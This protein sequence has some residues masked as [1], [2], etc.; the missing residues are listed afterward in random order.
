M[1]WKIFW[2]SLVLLHYF[3]RDK[4]FRFHTSH[5]WENSSWC[6]T[7][8]MPTLNLST[9]ICQKMGFHWQ[10]FGLPELIWFWIWFSWTKAKF[11]NCVYMSVW[12]IIESSSKEGGVENKLGNSLEPWQI[13]FLYLRKRQF[14]CFQ[15]LIL[16]LDHGALN[17]IC[18][19][20]V[21]K[22]SKT[23]KSG[24]WRDQTGNHRRFKEN[25]NVKV[26]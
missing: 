18:L 10:F 21:Q 25:M 1:L 23:G 12:I 22:G 19:T 9:Q 11:L 3:L 4:N 14:V 8:I 13:Y 7:D 15:I 26:C 2:N 16:Q 6:V 20:V 17:N 24:S 5:W